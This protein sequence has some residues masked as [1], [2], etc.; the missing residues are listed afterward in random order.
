MYIVFPRGYRMTIE[1]YNE[2]PQGWFVNAGVMCCFSQGTHLVIQQ[3]YTY[4]FF[5]VLS[6]GRHFICEIHCL[7][8]DGFDLN[9]VHKLSSKEKIFRPCQDSNLGLLGWKQ[10]CFFC[11]MQPPLPQLYQYFKRS[12]FPKVTQEQCYYSTKPCGV[13][14]LQVPLNCD[15]AQE[16]VFTL[17]SQQ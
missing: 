8:L 12:A 3:H 1:P 2:W 17:W 14:T 9:T 15:L 10:V 6:F 16:L 11:A 5:V 4:L 7:A 13:A